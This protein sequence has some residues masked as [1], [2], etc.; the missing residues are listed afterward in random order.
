[1]WTSTT[2][3]HGK[4]F[5]AKDKGNGPGGC[6]LWLLAD[7]K[8]LSPAEH[9]TMTFTRDGLMDAANKNENHWRATCSETYK[10][11]SEGGQ[12]KR[13]GSS[14][15]PVAYPTF[16]WAFMDVKQMQRSEGG[17]EKSF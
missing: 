7:A 17:S 6:R 14:T 1:M 13:A 16:V 3:E 5:N 15:S 10:R 8:L 4:T 11:R 12:G 2:S 9:V